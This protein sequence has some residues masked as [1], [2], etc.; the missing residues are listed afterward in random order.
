MQNAGS[1]LENRQNER[2]EKLEI[3]A[4]Y[5]LF[6]V[7]FAHFEPFFRWF[8]KVLPISLQCIFM[9]FALRLA[10]KRTAFSTKMHC[11]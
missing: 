5:L 4:F 6:K 2:R 11:V 1:V 3:V 8:E 10:P 9:L 7:F